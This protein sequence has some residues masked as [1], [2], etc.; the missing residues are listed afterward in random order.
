MQDQMLQDFSAATKTSY[1]AFQE[2]GQINTSA[3]E[4]LTQLQF[5]MATLGIEGTMEQAKLLTSTTNYKELLTAESDFAS[6]YSD[7]VMNIARQTAD[8]LTESRDEFT[9]WFEKN[10][11]VLTDAAQTASTAPKKPAARKPA[12]RKASSSTAKKSA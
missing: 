4:K 1:D 12:T 10:S 7:K 5:T 6:S 3:I 11:K 8:L 2:L 9:T